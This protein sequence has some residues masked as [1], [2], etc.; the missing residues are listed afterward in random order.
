MWCAEM[1]SATL[2]ISNFVH[3]Q[4]D[5]RKRVEI[6]EHKSSNNDRFGI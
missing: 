4:S 3:T 2:E 5:H 6:Y 1:Y